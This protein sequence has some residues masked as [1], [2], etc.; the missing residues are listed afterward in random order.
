M[1]S[2]RRGDRQGRL[3]SVQSAVSGH[4]GALERR[5]ERA[6]RSIEQRGLQGLHPLEEPAV[7]EQDT[8]PIHG[9]GSTVSDGA[10]AGSRTHATA[11]QPAPTK[12]MEDEPIGLDVAQAVAA[13]AAALL[14]PAPGSSLVRRTRLGSSVAR[15]SFLL[16]FLAWRRPCQCAARRSQRATR[17]APRRRRWPPFKNR[18]NHCVPDCFL[19]F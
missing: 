12:A 14:G 8:A 16:R 11:L 9:G 19:S 1:R 18:R 3:T 4:E 13:G 5:L 17:S 6:V 15:A 10:A 7:G 2:G